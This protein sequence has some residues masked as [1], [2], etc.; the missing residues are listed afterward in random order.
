MHG[1]DDVPD[2]LRDLMRPECKLTHR[3]G[4]GW[5]PVRRGVGEISGVPK[6]LLK[7]F[8]TRRRAIEAE[9]DRTG[10]SGR[11]AAQRAGRRWGC[12]TRPP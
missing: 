6:V 7:G 5:G 1:Q 3:L 9:L 8:S 12:A 2:L 10:G 11:A 4:V